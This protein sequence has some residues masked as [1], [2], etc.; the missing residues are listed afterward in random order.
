M[1]L[2]MRG[3]ENQK[4]G[5]REGEYNATQLMNYLWTNGRGE[6]A[7]RAST[8]QD[9]FDKLLAEFKPRNWHKHKADDEQCLIKAME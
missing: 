5:R 3:L 7:Q 6:E 1:T 8:D 9:L 2:M 4:K